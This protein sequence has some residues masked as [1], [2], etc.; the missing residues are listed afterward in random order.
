M[1][2]QFRIF[3]DQLECPS[4]VFKAHMWPHD[5]KHSHYDPVIAQ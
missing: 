2:S 1:K 3:G 4:Q 5:H